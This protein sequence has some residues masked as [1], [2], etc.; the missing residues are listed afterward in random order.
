V[1]KETE[2]N[3]EMPPSEQSLFLTKIPIQVRSV[4]S[5]ANQLGG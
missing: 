5:W 3:E 2:E 1:P 4:T